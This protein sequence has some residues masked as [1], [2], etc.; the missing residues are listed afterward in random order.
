MSGRRRRHL[1]GLY[2]YVIMQSLSRRK[3]EGPV[4]SQAPDGRVF[5]RDVEIWAQRATVSR[6]DSS[7]DLI[8]IVGKEN[9]WI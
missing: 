8:F 1:R 6:D 5:Q 9:V 4:C 7:A 3:Y 2:I